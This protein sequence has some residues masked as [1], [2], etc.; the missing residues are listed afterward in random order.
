MAPP[1]EPTRSART[2]ERM[3]AATIPTLLLNSGHAIPQLGFGVF[4]VDATETER[5][6]ADAIEAGYRHFDGARIYGNEE[7]LGRAIAA[8]GIPR[9]EFFVTTK[10]WKDDQGRHGAHAAL[11]A[12]LERLGM[13]SVDLYLIH[14]PHPGLGRAVETWLAFEELAAQGLAHSIGVSNFRQED[15]AAVIEASGTV[16]AVNQIEVH[17]LLQQTVLREFQEALGIRT[18]A[19]GPLGQGKVDLA[20][21]APVLVDIAAAHE[22]TV[23]QVVLRWHLQEGRIVFPKTTSPERMRENLAVVDFALTD[24]ELAAIRA[25]DQGRRLGP[26]PAIYD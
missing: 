26:D 8:S 4:K 3:S 16:P 10:L 13:E 14:W 15:L 21:E 2:L 17:P 20:V 22:R 6:V 25:L 19:W 23:A 11:E 7:G 1:D 18:E 9:E 24:D 5:I 12:S